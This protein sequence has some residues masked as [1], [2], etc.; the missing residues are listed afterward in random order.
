MDNLFQGYSK[1]QID[2]INKKLNAASKSTARTEKKV[3]ALFL[4]REMDLI[5]I[6]WNKTE[7]PLGISFNDVI[8]F[9]INNYLKNE[10]LDKKWNIDL[11]A[12]YRKIKSLTD[13]HAFTLIKV[14][15][16]K[17]ETPLIVKEG[18]SSSDVAN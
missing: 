7:A 16:K 9:H 4:E 15:L 17:D 8:I 5:R 13:Y 3:S 18:T 10:E 14:S 1:E 6:T 11:D 12:L 2:F